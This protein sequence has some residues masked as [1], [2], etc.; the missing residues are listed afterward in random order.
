MSQL[1]RMQNF[2]LRR[3]VPL[4]PAVGVERGGA[5]L[6]NKHLVPVE[7][8]QNWRFPV[9][10]VQVALSEAQFDADHEYAISFCKFR[11]Q[12]FTIRAI[13]A[14]ALLCAFMVWTST[15]FAFCARGKAYPTQNLALIT[16]VTL[17]FADT[18]WKFHKFP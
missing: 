16:M 14:K 8:G 12:K 4:T 5:H 1:A 9:S 10:H 17:V 15:Y 18:S 13:F 2:S 11:R 7:I 6:E 3:A